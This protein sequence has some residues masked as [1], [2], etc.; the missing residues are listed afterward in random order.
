MESATQWSLEAGDGRGEEDGIEDA[1]A[2]EKD[3]GDLVEYVRGS[4]PGV[5]DADVVRVDGSP[6]NSGADGEA[7]QD[8]V[9]V[10]VLLDPAHYRSTGSAG[11]RLMHHRTVRFHA[12]RCGSCVKK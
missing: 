8:Q 10:G 4:D 9:A 5:D 1:L 7:R 6:A 3:C 2:G 11:D 12:F